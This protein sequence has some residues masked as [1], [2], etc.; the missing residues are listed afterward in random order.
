MGPHYTFTIS[1][2]HIVQKILRLPTIEA[3]PLI[4]FLWNVRQRWQVPLTNVIMDMHCCHILGTKDRTTS[5][6]ALYICFA[7]L[8]YFCK[9]LI[10]TVKSW[11]YSCYSIAAFPKYCGHTP[12]P[13]CA[14]ASDGSLMVAVRP[15][16]L[17]CTI[18]RSDEGVKYCTKI[19]I[20]ILN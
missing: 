16:D 4:I 18:R 5:G 12:R 19:S 2:A 1:L 13:I 14:C 10:F 11:Q 7:V 9:L 15:V 17:K 20:S 8:R 6:T 3:C